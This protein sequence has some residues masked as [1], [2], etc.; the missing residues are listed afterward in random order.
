MDMMPSKRLRMRLSGIRRYLVKSK[1]RSK[2]R[3]RRNREIS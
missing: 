2:A 1:A 3:S